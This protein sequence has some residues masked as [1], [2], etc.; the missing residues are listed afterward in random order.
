[1]KDLDF[2]ELDRAVTSVLGDRSAEDG[3]TQATDNSPAGVF[4][5]PSSTPV[6]SISSHAV[7]SRII[8]SGSPARRATL[9]RGSTTSMTESTEKTSAPSPA[10]QK[11]VIPHRAGRFMDVVHPGRAAKPAMVPMTTEAEVADTPNMPI[12]TEAP[13]QDVAE[14]APVGGFAQDTDMEKAIN[15]LLASEGHAVDTP[16]ETATPTSVETEMPV[17]ASDTFALEESTPNTQEPVAENEPTSTEDATLAS[18][19]EAPLDGSQDGVV[20]SPFL[21]D[22][23]VEKRPLGSGESTAHELPTPSPE[24]LAAAEAPVA[25]EEPHMPPVEDTAEDAPLPEELQDNLLAIESESQATTKTPTDETSVPEAKPE[26]PVSIARQYKETIKTASENDEAGAIFDPQTYQQ[27]IEHP[28][29]KS[30][31]WGWVV[32]IVVIILVAVAATVAAWMGNL[33]PVPL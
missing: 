25:T 26:A 1:M 12:E 23:K 33:L 17:A 30:S 28:A 32:A 21:P 5:Q 10:S 8:P 2:D 20:D 14:A 11:R 15:D 4:S 9:S 19:L 24:A 16:P 7:H 31:G 13:V 29:K 27:P 3:A 22:A 18:A 6:P